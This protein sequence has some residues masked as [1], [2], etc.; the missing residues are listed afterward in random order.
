ALRE[1]AGTLLSGHFSVLL[2]LIFLPY[3]TLIS[4]D[5]IMRTLVRRTITRKRL[6]QWE[7]AAQAEVATH[8][9]PVDYY[10]DVTP[11]LAMLITAALASWRA[12]ALPVAGP[13][14]FLWFSSKVI[15]RWLDRPPRREKNALTEKDRRFLRRVALRTWRFFRQYGGPDSN[16]LIP[17]Y[18]Q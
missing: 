14:L 9:T 13:L 18:V 1:A 6:L 2:W 7:T 17:D 15:S 16:H 10:L 5:A 11:W 4:L 12:A 8:R 3:Q